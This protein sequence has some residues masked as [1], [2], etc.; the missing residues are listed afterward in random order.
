[1]FDALQYA[2]TNNV[3]P[4][5]SISYGNCEKNLGS[6]FVQTMQQWAEEANAQ[7]QTISGPAGDSGAADCDTGNSATQGLAVDVP[8]SIPEVTGVG[9]SEFTGDPDACTNGTCPN[10]IA[11]ADT[12]WSGASTLNSGP[13]ALKYI[14]EEGWD[15]TTSNSGL[16]AT[17]G[18]ASIIFGKPSW[19]A[20]TGVPS[21]GKRD[22]PDI[23]LNASNAHDPYLI[24]SRDFYTGQS[25][26]AVSCG[27]G[28]RT[29]DTNTDPKTTFN[30]SLSAVGGTSAGAPTF[31]GILALVN[32]ATNSQGL[33][34]VNPMLYS[35]AASSPAA[36]HDITSGNN[37]VPCTSGT[38]NCPAGTNTIGFSAGTGYDQVTGLGSLDVAQL[39]SAWTAVTPAG[40]FSLDSLVSSASAAGQSGTSTISVNALQGFT[41]T[42]SLS[43]T[44]SSTTKLSCSVNPSSVTLTSSTAGHTA[45]ATVTISSI[46]D[47]RLP[48]GRRPRGLW[49]VSASGIFAAVM[50]G[51]IPSSR[52]RYGMFLLLMFV[53]AVTAIGCGGGSR[54]APVQQTQ[55]PQTYS[56]TVTGTGTNSAG[57]ALTHTTTLSF[58]VQ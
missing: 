58:T 26:T 54:P 28:F 29:T 12:Y 1:V 35:L 44:P 16:D 33:G 41:G 37:N 31:A 38:T 6:S 43:C 8:A 49:L 56:V 27:N 3:A 30:N 48:N 42:V 17:G 47:V 18:G 13:T 45:T 34:N 55:A 24:C 53:T 9:G 50:L 14:P 15:D 32:Q 57:T 20:G 39:V 2:I 25:T 23:A 5:I 52:R 46:A 21:D 40:D 4:I 36:F 7:G 11:P 10:N 22:V 51:G 19:Q